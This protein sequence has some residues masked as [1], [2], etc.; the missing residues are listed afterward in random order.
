MGLSLIFIASHHLL[1]I[2]PSKPCKNPTVKKNSHN[3]TV[4]NPMKTMKSHLQVQFHGVFVVR[5][6]PIF[7]GDLAIVFSGPHLPT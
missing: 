1:G 6:H 7:V 2:L 4:K 5:S 3:P